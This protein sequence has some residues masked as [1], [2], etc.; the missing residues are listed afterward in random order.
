MASSSSFWA[1]FAKAL[2]FSL[3]CGIVGPIFL[4][5]Y[6]LI[7]DESVGWLLWWG[8]VITI[9]DVL[10][11]VAMAGAG[12]LVPRPSTWRPSSQLY[13]SP[14]PPVSPPAPATGTPAERMAELDELMK[15]D[16]ISTEEYDASRKRILG[17]L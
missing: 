1:S 7:D 13:G 12:T 3:L 17:E 8:L 15:R 16:L 9:F 10:L 11:A 5:L 4:T 6:F 2:P 14:A